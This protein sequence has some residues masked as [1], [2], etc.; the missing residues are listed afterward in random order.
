V[1]AVPSG[2]KLA[3][4]E[5]FLG[6]GKHVLVEKPLVIPDRGALERL[7]RLA[8]DRG[9]CWYTSYNYRF[10]PLIIKLR[11]LYRSGAIGDLYYARMVVANGSVANVAGTWRDA[12]LGAIEDLACHLFD[13]TPWILDQRPAFTTW[14]AQRHEAKAPDHA[15]VGGA[16][17]R[18]VLD[19]S[20]LSWKNQFRI[21]LIGAR[22][23]LHLSGMRK[24]GPCDLIL[25]ERILP[26]GVPHETVF[27]D[28]GPDESWQRDFAEFERRVASKTTSASDD[29]WVSECLRAAGRGVAD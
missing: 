25:R 24:W 16:D 12:G 1:L 10:E 23:S 7:E 3:Q 19:V 11:D 26:S 15:I 29:W 13:L 5:R 28:E 9:V 2:A 14:T 8:R 4:L 20:Y 21:D 22:G 27:H 6:L 17:G 18:L